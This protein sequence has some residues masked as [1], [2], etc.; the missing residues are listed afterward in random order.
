MKNKDD[1]DIIV[2]TNEE[3]HFLEEFLSHH[4]VT[5]TREKG[6]LLAR[7]GL[8]EQVFEWQDGNQLPWRGEWQLSEDGERFLQ[9]QAER[10]AESRKQT[11]LQILGIITPFI[12]FIL[13]LLA[14]RF[15]GILG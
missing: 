1:L 7:H 5:A 13:G 4:I 10:K 8:I 2:L 9:Y 6:H 11:K 12:T 14:E 3:K 15:L